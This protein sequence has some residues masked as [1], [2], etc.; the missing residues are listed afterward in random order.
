[1]EAQECVHRF[2]PGAAQQVLLQHT[3]QLLVVSRRRLHG[4]TSFAHMMLAGTIGTTPA[5]LAVFGKMCCTCKRL[6]LCIPQPPRSRSRSRKSAAGWAAAGRSDQPAASSRHACQLAHVT[7]QPTMPAPQLRRALCRMQATTIN[8]VGAF[9]GSVLC[10]KLDA[11]KSHD[12]QCVFEH[13]HLDAVRQEQ[14]PRESVPQPYSRSLR[15]P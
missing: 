9:G 3:L 15:E 8:P 4:N 14:Q 6:V 1:M 12:K 13:H 10:S 2:G 11:A 7:S 5:A